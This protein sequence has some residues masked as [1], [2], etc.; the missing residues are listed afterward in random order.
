MRCSIPLQR[1]SWTD[2]NGQPPAKESECI[3]HKQTVLLGVICA[4]ATVTIWATFLVG[5]RFAVKSTFTVQEILFL[6]LVPA[7]LIM[8]PF[9]IKLGIWPKGQSWFGVFFISIGAS[10]IFP[11]FVTS[12]LQFAPA[13]DAGALAPGMIPIWT[14]LAAYFITGERPKKMAL[15]GLIMILVGVLMVGLWPSLFALNFTVLKGYLLCF[16]GA[17]LFSIYAVIY[18]QSGITALHSLVI[19]LFWGALLIGPGLLLF[20]QVPFAQA[21]LHDIFYMLILQGIIIA[22]LAL[23][24][25]N[26]AVNLLGAP[27]AA[28]FGALTPVLALLGGVWLLGEVASPLKIA[29]VTIV[30]AG[31]FLASGVMPAILSRGFKF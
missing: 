2:L 23:L 26:L 17:G 14:A 3:I 22:I 8:S 31:V 13:S 12:G 20:G 9:M 29:G 28:A 16:T 4:I 11:L 21:E 27:Q 19:G 30:S 10:V 25:F 24:L 18:R 5:T 6:R 7:A 15:C 1:Q